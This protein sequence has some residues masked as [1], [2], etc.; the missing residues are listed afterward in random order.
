MKNLDH[1]L[2]VDEKKKEKKI[3][4]IARVEKVLYVTF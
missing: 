4:I 1:K 3:L 2:Q